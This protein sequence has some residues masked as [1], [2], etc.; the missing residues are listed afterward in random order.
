MKKIC[1][2]FALIGIIVLTSLIF[3]GEN[4][5]EYMRIHIRANSNSEA[6]QAVKY[7]IRDKIVEYL[8]PLVSSCADENAAKQ[9]VK[10]NID[11]INS[12]AEAELKKYGF[13]YGCRSNVLRETFPTRVYEDVTLEYGEYDALIIELGTGTGD[14]WWCVVYPP[15]CFVGDS[16][17]GEIKYKSYILEL[18][19]R[20]G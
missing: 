8:S 4:D 17:E 12:I 14:N 10:D 11:T 7:V 20:I 9:T 16:G 19:E 1:I 2:S 18:I 15:L 6:D 3:C 5:S 13:D